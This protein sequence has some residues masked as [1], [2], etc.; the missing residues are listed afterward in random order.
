MAQI[1]RSKN[2]ATKFQILLEIARKQPNIQ[3]REVARQ[4]NITAQAVSGYVREMVSCGWL[5]S[6][7]RSQYRVT[8]EGVDWILRMSR[9][10]QGYST[11]VSRVVR[12]ISTSTAIAA[13]DLSGG[14]QVS[15]YMENGLLFAST[16]DGGGG[17]KGVA[18]SSADHG[19]DVGVSDVEGLISLEAG[20]IIICK[21]PSVQRGGSR[22]TNLDRLRIEV[23]KVKHVG[24]IG[25][26]ALVAL[27]QI[28]LESVY[29]YGA[30]EAAIEA[31]HCGLFVALV[32][33]ADAVP[34]LAQSLGEEGINYR[35][36]DL[37]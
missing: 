22:N 36:I 14:Q 28:G 12:D 37:E 21:I 4:I 7:G 27:R 30:K 6:Q 16:Y 1:L 9:E 34:A 31:A 10:L 20:E 15:L 23:N 3:Q 19:W 18:I 32:C 29:L 13:G 2:L 35:I 8:R 33:V 26:E 25:I 17:A 24:A 11:F 5:S